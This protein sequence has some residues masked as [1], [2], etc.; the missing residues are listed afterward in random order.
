VEMI[1]RETRRYELHSIEH[2]DHPDF[3]LGCL[4]TPGRDGA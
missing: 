2:P 4:R 1:E 3:A